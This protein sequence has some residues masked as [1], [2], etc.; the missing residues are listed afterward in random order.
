MGRGR[1]DCF[2][3]SV[4]CP[5]QAILTRR[6]EDAGHQVSGITETAESWSTSAAST[7]STETDIRTERTDVKHKL[8]IKR[9]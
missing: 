4:Y 2:R 1:R 9:D 7:W 6:M 3:N 5:R 8:G